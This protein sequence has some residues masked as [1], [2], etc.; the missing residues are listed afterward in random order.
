MPRKIKTCFFQLEGPI[1]QQSVARGW[2]YVTDANALLDYPEIVERHSPKE[3]IEMPC[4]R[5]Q[6]EMTF[7][8]MTDKR[9]I[10]KDRFGRKW[11]VYA[12]HIN[13]L[14]PRMNKGVVEAW[15]SI[16][17]RGSMYGIVADVESPLGAVDVDFDVPLMLDT[18]HDLRS[19]I[20]NFEA[21]A[22]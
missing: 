19:V 9:I 2:A 12:S 14:V 11:S 5:F 21:M 20:P 13:E 1:R 3:L 10:M 15:W 22:T 6:A 7:S 4:I 8:H 17:K 18:V 16:V